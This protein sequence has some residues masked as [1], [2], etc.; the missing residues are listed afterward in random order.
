MEAPGGTNYPRNEQL[1]YRCSSPG[2]KC[3]KSSILVLDVSGIVPGGQ[4]V[5]VAGAQHPDLVGQQLAVLAQRLPG[6]LAL[7]MG[8]CA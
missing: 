8:D 5:G 7:P 6:F 3:V 4:G 1:I 2:W